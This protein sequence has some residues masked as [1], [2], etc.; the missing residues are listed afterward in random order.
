MATAAELLGRPSDAARYQAL[1]T[2]ARAV[3]R[4][5]LVN[6]STGVVWDGSQTSQV[7]AL[8]L[9]LNLPPDVASAATKHLLHDVE[10]LHSGHLDTGIIGTK[11]SST[12]LDW[13]SVA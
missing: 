10:V 13:C 5:T 6:A 8:A 3:F 4:D 12:L 9:G 1:G 11:Y 2:S 7:L